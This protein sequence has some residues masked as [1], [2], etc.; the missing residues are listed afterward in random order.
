M[1]TN[2]TLQ[3]IDIY[4]KHIEDLSMFI[5]RLK[6]RASG[7]NPMIKKIEQTTYFTLYE[8]QREYSIPISVDAE[9][10]IVE[11]AEK[12]LERLKNKLKELIND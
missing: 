4:R 6:R 2:S 7:C 5:D 12:E 8:S 1:Y 9:F 3:K 11:E 10:I